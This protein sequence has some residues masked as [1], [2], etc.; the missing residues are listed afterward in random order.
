MTNFLHAKYDSSGNQIDDP[1]VVIGQPSY[2]TDPLTGAVTGLVGPGGGAGAIADTVWAGNW[3]LYDDSTK[4]VDQTASIL[5]LIAD[6]TT[7]QFSGEIIF[8][9]GDICYT[10]PVDWSG[11]GTPGHFYYSATATYI[12]PPKLKSANVGGTR[13]RALNATSTN[14]TGFIFSVTDAMAATGITRV[15]NPRFENIDF[16]GN[17]NYITQATLNADAVAGTSIVLTTATAVVG[18]AICLY[19]GAQRHWAT[20]K[21]VSGAGPQTVTIDARQALMQTFTSAAAKVLLFK[22]SR[23]LQFGGTRT[24]ASTVVQEVKF[25]NVRFF[26]SFQGIF[27]D[28]TTLVTGDQVL[29]KNVINGIAYGYNIDTVRLNAPY[30]GSD[31]PILT[32]ATCTNGS[33]Q[34]TGLSA[35][36][37]ATVKVGEKIWEQANADGTLNFP[38]HTYVISAVGTTITV[39]NNYSGTTGSKSLYIGCG[40]LVV[41][42]KGSTAALGNYSANNLNNYNELIIDNPIAGRIEKYLELG[43]TVGLCCTINGGYLESSQRL[44]TIGQLGGSGSGGPLVMPNFWIQDINALIAPAVEDFLGGTA[45]YDM[46]IVGAGNA[47]FP[48]FQTRSNNPSIVLRHG[49]SWN[50]VSTAAKGFGQVSPSTVNLSTSDGNTAIA[51][52]QGVEWSYNVGNYGKVD[53]NGGVIVNPAFSGALNWNWPGISG[54][55]LKLT[56]NLTAGSII[57]G[58]PPKGYKLKVVLTQDA[59]GTRTVTLGSAFVTGAGAAVTVTGSAANAVCVLD[60]FSDGVHMVLQGNQSP[61]FI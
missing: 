4:S 55:D 1:T 58:Q 61:T 12:T 31:R 32:G 24:A 5:R 18:D 10:G 26:D 7:A 53:G 51:L 50:N 6:L 2:A 45:K 46:R 19:N 14:Y 59:T 29:F 47:L 40:I 52:P 30:I 33:N 8:P 22:Q 37:V 48:M 3:G 49:W 60:F 42:G 23:L 39:S 54:L 34:I 56:G 41:N 28:D 36:T 43:D 11:C 13:F 25:T 44:A 21:A 57:Y 9:A 35:G 20:V 27:F 15:C 16:Y 17:G 38:E